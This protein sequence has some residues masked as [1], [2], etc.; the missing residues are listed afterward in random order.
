MSQT[1]TNDL[2]NSVYK[3]IYKNTSLL[4]KGETNFVRYLPKAQTPLRDLLRSMNKIEGVDKIERRTI[5][6]LLDKAIGFKTAKK[7]RNPEL[8]TIFKDRINEYYKLKDVLPDNIKL[9]L[10]EYKIEILKD[11][12]IIEANFFSKSAKDKLE[13]IGG[14]AQILKK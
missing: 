10:D 7:Y 1:A 2:I 11:K 14:T 8:Y 3:D 12:I 4:G 13:K 9:N 5:T 6:D